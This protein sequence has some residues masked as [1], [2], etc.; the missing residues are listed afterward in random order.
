VYTP[1]H[2]SSAGADRR[3]FRKPVYQVEGNAEGY[4]ISVSM[5][6]VAKEGV[7]IALHGRNLEIE[8]TRRERPNE[9][10][11]PVL[12]ELNWDDYRLHLELNVLVNESAISAQV[13]DGVLRLTLPKA[14]EAKPRRIE[15]A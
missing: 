9:S 5:P 6:G 13:T 1:S 2:E 15:V 12:S 10:W 8:G 14:E 7:N 4:Q 3:R 11:R